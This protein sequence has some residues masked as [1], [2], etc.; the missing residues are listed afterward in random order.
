MS[1]ASVI[2][3]NGQTLEVDLTGPVET[4]AVV[5]SSLTT[6]VPIL[7]AP[8]GLAWSPTLNVAKRFGEGYS[9][10]VDVDSYKIA[11]TT[12][13]MYFSPTGSNA[14]NG[15]TPA[16][17][18]LSVGV[19]VAALNATPPT[20]GATFI[21]APGTYVNAAPGQLSPTFAF[22]L[23]CPEGRAIFINPQV[24]VW[25]KLSGYTNVYRA[26]SM[27]TQTSTRISAIDL[28]NLD[29]RGRPIR[30]VRVASAALCDATPNS[31]YITDT[32]ISI[33]T[34]DSRV[35]DASISVANPA[36][37]A[38][39]QQVTR[40]AFAQNCDFWGYAQPLRIDGPGGTY[41]FDNCSFRYSGG[42]TN[43]FETA[44]TCTSAL[45]LILNNC[46][47]SYN[48]YDG[49]GYRG[50]HRVAELGC[51]AEYNG[52][53]GGNTADN[54]TTA[55]ESVTTIRVGGV[56]QYNGDRNVHDIGTTKNWLVN[57]VAGYPQNGS[58]ETYTEG[59]FVV[60]RKLELDATQT[61]L[62]ECESLPGSVLDLG[63]YG[64]STATLVDCTGM[65]LRETDGTA[66]IIG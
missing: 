9:A 63:V 33:H 35:P 39:R 5:H 17:P 61:W 64:G 12:L 31:V 54:G 11:N 14:N 66:T 4:T 23:L 16:T 49:F 3:Y 43:G 53:D 59:N 51:I 37:F 1:T 2:A 26:S 6:P 34:F 65:T 36:S 32:T 21:L 22:N 10:R 7:A 18:K 24:P 57:C 47:A 46:D 58:A 27:L 62:T 52:Y 48:S 8:A 38:W 55:H 30:L 20:N 41:F 13:T 42:Q 45:T 44:S 15:L 19:A 29:E 60:G 56:Y 25:S 40:S 28:T 50:A